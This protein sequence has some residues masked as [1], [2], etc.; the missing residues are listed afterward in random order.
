MNA[1]CAASTR[2]APVDAA[3]VA[4]HLERLPDRIAR[5]VDRGR[6]DSRGRVDHAV[7]L[8][9]EDAAEHGDTHRAARLPG[10]V[11]DRRAHARPLARQRSHDRLGDRR[12]GDAHAEPVDQADPEADRERRH[13]RVGRVQ[14][15]RRRHRA[16]A[17]HHH[18]RRT[19]AAD[20]SWCVGRAHHQ[21][22][23]HRHEHDPRLQRAV[24]EPEL[25]VLREQERRA[26]HR[27]LREGDR[28][29]RGGEARVLEDADVE[30]RPRRVTLP[31]DEGRRGTRCRP[32]TPP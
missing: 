22:D 12:H 9:R 8:E 23:R 24:A 26:E 27:E 19:E 16:Q 18:A 2:R 15:G 29:R 30:H 28:G 17:R 4:R 25:E 5:V 14:R 31:P 11:V 10:G 21:A 6:G 13:Q 20:Q 1:C 32:R 7:V 3:H